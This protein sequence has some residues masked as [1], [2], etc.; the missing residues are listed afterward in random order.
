ML[1]LWD[2]TGPLPRNLR[3]RTPGSLAFPR[4]E[5]LQVRDVPARGTEERPGL[6]MEVG[7]LGLTGPSGVLPSV[8][9]ELVESRRA[10]YQDTALH[11][12]LDVFSHRAVS[13]FYLAWLKYRFYRGAEQGL[14]D[15][16]SRNLMA[17]LGLGLEAKTSQQGLGGLNG[18]CLHFGGILGRRPIPSGSLRA[19]VEGHLGVPVAMEQFVFHWVQVAGTDQSRLGASA[20]D[21]LGSG[22]FLGVRQRDAQTSI[23]L[24]LGPLDARQFRDFLPDGK[25][26]SDLSALMFDLLGPTMRVEVRLILRRAEVPLPRMGQPGGLSLGRN[27]WMFSTPPERD[28]SDAIYELN[29]NPA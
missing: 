18:T 25:G 9:T 22:T 24:L 28:Q 20:R 17:L 5:I 1:S 3:F 16:F 7:F 11:A 29:M 14:Q 13:L 12:F 6:E 15:G 21:G 26:G 4:A 27:L 2:K 19:V 10:H 8:Y 23:R